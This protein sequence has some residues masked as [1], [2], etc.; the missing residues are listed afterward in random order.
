MRFST[1][2]F[3]PASLTL[4]A[5]APAD[6]LAQIGGTIAIRDGAS[7]S[8]TV[9]VAGYSIGGVNEGGMSDQEAI[10]ADEAAADAQAASAED[11]TAEQFIAELQSADNADHHG[12]HHHDDD[13]HKGKAYPNPFDHCAKYEKGCKYKGKTLEEGLLSPGVSMIS[14]HLKHK[15]GRLNLRRFA[16]SQ[17]LSSLRLT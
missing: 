7:M 14:S 13:D 9:D 11:M 10:L 6:R 3:F 2:V 16:V 12:H 15:R 4:V 17:D 8:N 1:V 5:A